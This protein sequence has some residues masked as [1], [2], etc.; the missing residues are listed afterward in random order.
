LL[1][2]SV[3][4]YREIESGGFPTSEVYERI[5]DLFGWPRTLVQ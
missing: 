2:V 5:C 3:R 4:E 1:G